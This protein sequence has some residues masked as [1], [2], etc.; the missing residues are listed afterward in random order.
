MLMMNGGCLPSTGSAVSVY[1]ALLMP[2]LL[3][4][5]LLLQGMYDKVD[6]LQP[7][8]AAANPVQRLKVPG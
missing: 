3:V 4:L 5:V 8:V 1:V 2:M 6:Q 7:L